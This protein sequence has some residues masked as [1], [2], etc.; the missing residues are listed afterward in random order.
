MNS[1]RV[2]ARSGSNKPF[3]L[4]TTILSSAK[5][6]IL[7]E[8][9]EA[10]LS[11]KLGERKVKEEELRASIVGQSSKRRPREYSTVVPSTS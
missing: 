9:S 10:A 3:L 4:P 7:S 11:L 8:N 5:A 2:I 1:A 6:S